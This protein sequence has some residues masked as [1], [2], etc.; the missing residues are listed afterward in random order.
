MKIVITGCTGLLGSVLVRRL[1]RDHEIIGITRNSTMPG[2]KV[3]NIDIADGDAVYSAI[4]KINPDL[5]IHT[6]TMTNVDECENDP[7][8][9]YRVNAL[10]ARNIAVACQRFDTVLAHISTD[11]VF[12]GMDAPSAGYSEFDKTDP[13]GVYAVSKLWG[14]W[15]VQRLLNKFFIIRTS[16]L[17]GSG[18]A[19]FVSA[20]KNAI[21]SNA[22]MKQAVDMVSA[23]TYV[24][25]LSDALAKLIE[26][27]MYGT[28]HITNAGF[29]S[30]HNVA[31]FIAK[32]YGY[33]E[34]KIE[35]VKLSELN[36]KAPRPLFSGLRN[37][38]WE[39][40]GFKPL[41]PWQKAVADYLA[42]NQL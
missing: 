11:Y 3:L 4:S 30:R 39:L 5:V 12:S 29:V 21:S 6:A 19:N 14:E 32:I 20:I 31:S 9:A 22:V 16:W 40:N 17:F 35:K 10:G 25:D 1:E 15:Y 28:Y 26:T 33:P 2:V 18:R 34:A 27:N 42:E 8:T 7:D 37:H 36:L 24:V 38:V 41:R 23:P 13:K